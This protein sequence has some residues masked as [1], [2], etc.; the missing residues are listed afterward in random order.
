MT[1]DPFSAD[2]DEPQFAFVNELGLT[3]V[4]R[5]FR[6]PKNPRNPRPL[7]L[8]SPSC[9]L[10]SNG[11]VTALNEPLDA[12]RHG[13]VALSQD[14]LNETVA[15]PHTLASAVVVAANRQ[16]GDHGVVHRVFVVAVVAGWLAMRWS[17]TSSPGRSQ[18]AIL[19]AGSCA[20]RLRSS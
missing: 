17:R 13:R 10:R 15:Q 14:N 19:I 12:L 3:T 6:C 20:R 5:R 7:L 16:A 8:A 18:L 11:L 9:Y 2:M 1:T 4:Q